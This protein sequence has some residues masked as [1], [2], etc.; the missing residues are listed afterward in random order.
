M[1][2][3]GS[4]Y[5][6]TIAVIQLIGCVLRQHSLLDDDGKYFINS[7]DFTNEFHRV[8]FGTISNL[9]NM[10]TQSIGIKEIEDYLDKRPESLAVYKANNGPDW[11]KSAIENA[12]LPNFDYYYNKIKK[13][14]LLRNY[15]ELGLN[16][17]W[18]YDVDNILDVKKKQNQENYLDSLSLNE[19]ADLI[20][21]KILNIR[22]KC[23]DNATDESKAI[24]NSVFDILSNLEEKP[25]IGSPLYG[26]YVNLMHRG[27]RMGKFYLRSAA[28]GVG[29]I[30]S[31]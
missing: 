6:D 2:F 22:E 7:S 15:D 13:M 8:V 25:E 17:S 9:Y 20:D 29:N 26:K 28:T 12:D 3:M 11:L 27:A 5:Y 10:G 16:I 31:F 24:G 18:L 14:T 19:I 4:K 1:I 21:N 30:R 23:I